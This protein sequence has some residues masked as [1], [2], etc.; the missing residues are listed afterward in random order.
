MRAAAL[1]QPT[2][3]VIIVDAP[4]VYLLRSIPFRP[5]ASSFPC[6]RPLSV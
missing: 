1:P 5:F 2:L 3:C 6:S 4:F